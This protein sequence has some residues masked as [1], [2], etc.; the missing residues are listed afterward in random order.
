VIVATLTLLL[1]YLPI[2]VLFGFVPL[3]FTTLLLLIGITGLYV[4]A[5][6]IVKHRFYRWMM[7]TS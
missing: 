3:P 2:S 1:P 6:E 7:P 4:I 5:T